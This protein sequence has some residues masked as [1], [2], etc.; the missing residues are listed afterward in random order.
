[1]RLGCC[2]ALRA[3]G[4]PKYGESF[5]V[6]E[7]R[8]YHKKEVRVAVPVCGTPY[9]RESLLVEPQMTCCLEIHIRKTACEH[10]IH[11]FASHTSRRK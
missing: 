5:P 10:D 4:V 9:F 1:M 2:N 3:I 8:K 7:H 6:L 11:I